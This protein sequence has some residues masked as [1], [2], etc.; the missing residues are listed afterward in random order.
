VWKHP[1]VFL[2]LQNIVTHLDHYEGVHWKANAIKE[3]DMEQYVQE[4]KVSIYDYISVVH[5]LT[6]NSR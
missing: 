6:Q 2:C 3:F 1:N 4:Q 5:T